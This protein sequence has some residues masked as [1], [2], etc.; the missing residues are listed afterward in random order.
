M[1]SR[2]DIDKIF[3]ASR[4]EEVIQDFVTL[5]KSGSNYKGLSPFS[6]EKTPS[7]CSFSGKTNMERF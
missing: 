2:E 7:F 6:N 3:D 4:V 5:K 1:I